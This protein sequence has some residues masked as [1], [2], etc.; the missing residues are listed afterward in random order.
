VQIKQKKIYIKTKNQLFEFQI[1]LSIIDKKFEWS[2][3]KKQ[4]ISGVTGWIYQT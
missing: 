4:I 2:V 3:R 1:Y